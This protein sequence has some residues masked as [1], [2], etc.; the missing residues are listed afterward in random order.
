LLKLIL[1]TFFLILLLQ[2]PLEANSWDLHAEVFRK[3]SSAPIGP[4]FA[5]VTVTGTVVDQSGMPIPGVTVLVK[6]T[7]IGTSTDLDGKYSISIPE[8]STL[9]FSFI[10]FE[11]R[12][13]VV[14][15]QTVIN[16]TLNEDIS[17][18]DEVVVVG[19]GTQKKSV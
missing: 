18:L 5:D 17:S 16:I 19:Y 12:A 6:G 13:I 1:S 7:T 9:V 11:S 2:G 15:G 3:M 10:G 8:G 14:D 4:S